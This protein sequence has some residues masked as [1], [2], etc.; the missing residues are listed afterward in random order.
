MK[1]FFK[2]AD[3]SA[4][5]GLG[6]IAVTV[7]ILAL[8]IGLVVLL[9]ASMARDR[10]RSALMWVLISIVGSPLLAILLLIALGNAPNDPE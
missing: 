9:P 10:N 5:E 7:I 4:F 1:H 3:L 6:A 8:I 2:E